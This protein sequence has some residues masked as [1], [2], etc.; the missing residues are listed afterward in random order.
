MLLPVVG[1]IAF[2]SAINMP[3]SMVVNV[4]LHTSV[5]VPH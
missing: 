1:N 2:S 3:P 5:V 4:K